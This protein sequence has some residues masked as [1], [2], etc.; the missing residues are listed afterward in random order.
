MHDDLK[1]QLEETGKELLEVL[2]HFSDEKFNEIPAP[3]KWSAGQMSDHVL[4]SVSGFADIFL[5]PGHEADRAPDEMFT[6]LGGIFLN[7]DSPLQSPDFIL[8]RGDYFP[9]DA[10]LNQIR[11]GFD[12]MVDA[13]DQVDLKEFGTELPRLGKMTKMEMIYFITVHTKRHIHQAKNI[14]SM[15]KSAA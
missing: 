3:G 4:Q 7:F 2:R 12:A 15:L 1:E 8:P 11:D 9:K 5:K 6:Q 10:I 13:F 14:E